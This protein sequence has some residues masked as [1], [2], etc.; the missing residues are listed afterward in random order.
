MTNFF[1]PLL[2][3]LAVE[4]GIPHLS[5]PAQHP[6]EEPI[7][8]SLLGYIKLGEPGFLFYSERVVVKLK[9]K[10]KIYASVTAVFV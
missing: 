7:T 1:L 9:A 10:G 4:E 3:I 8:H 5:L 2:V 6:M